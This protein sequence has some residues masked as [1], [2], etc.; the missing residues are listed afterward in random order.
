[1][2]ERRIGS[3][4]HELQHFER[5]ARGVLPP[6]SLQFPVRVGAEAQFELDPAQPRVESRAQPTRTRPLARSRTA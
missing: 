5:E 2:V 1:M 3:L 6:R 4:L